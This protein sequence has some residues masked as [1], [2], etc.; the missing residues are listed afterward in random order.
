ML[1]KFPSHFKYPGNELALPANEI[2]L[3][4]GVVLL[5]AFIWFWIYPV[6]PLRNEK[7]FVVMP[8]KEPWKE[9]FSRTTKEVLIWTCVRVVNAKNYV[10]PPLGVFITDKSV[11]PSNYVTSINQSVKSFLERANS[12]VPL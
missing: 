7:V 12:L 3:P 4:T 9:M 8:F 11:Q 1:Y 2:T 6:R 5:I 10:S